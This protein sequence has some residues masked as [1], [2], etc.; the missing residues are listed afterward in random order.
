MTIAVGADLADIQK[1]IAQC[2]AHA[3]AQRIILIAR[4]PYDGLNDTAA[5]QNQD[6]GHEQQSRQRLQ[7]ARFSRRADH[8]IFP[9]LVH[10]GLRHCCST[11]NYC[12]TII[13]SRTGR[14]G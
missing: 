9:L 2:F 5:G 13:L 4:V 14:H 1:Q 6:R 3:L 8:C 7:P 12:L 10:R 11:T